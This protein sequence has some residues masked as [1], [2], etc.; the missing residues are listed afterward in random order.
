MGVAKPVMLPTI[1]FKKQ[2]EADAFFKAMLDSYDD[3]E[4]LNSADEELV[5]ELLQR[6]PESETKIGCGVVG[7]FRAHS[8][9]HPSSCFHVRRADGTETDFSYKTCVRGT[10]PSLK[11]RFYEACQRSITSIVTTQKRAL[12]EAA[13]G[14]IACNKTGTPTTFSTSDY[15]HTHPRFRDIVEDFIKI[16]NI[17]ISESLLS[18]GADMQYSTTFI[19]PIMALTFAEYHKTVAKLEI[20]RR[21][22]IPSFD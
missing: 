5:Y 13:E 9:D 14:K 6:H 4:Y 10:S 21:F 1:Q 15:R 2:G 12:F 8:P 7:I 22:E 11:S 20:F 18:K 19:D 3:K 17:V 16:N